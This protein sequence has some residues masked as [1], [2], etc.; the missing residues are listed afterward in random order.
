MIRHTEPDAHVVVVA[1]DLASLDSVRHFADTLPVDAV[2][3]LV[4]NAATMTVQRE[5]T[6]D[7]FEMMFGTNVLGHFALVTA[8]LDR[9][10]AAETPRVVTQS[11][12]GHR[13]GRLDFDDLQHERSFSG[14]S[15]YFDAKLAQHVLAVELDRRLAAVHSVVSQPGWVVTEL[16]RDIF[17]RGPLPTRAVFRLGNAVI[18]Q[19][20]EDG[21]RS[22]LTAALGADVPG[23]ATGQYVTPTKLNRLR[24]I[25]DIRPADPRVLDHNLGTRLWETASGLSAWQSHPAT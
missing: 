5:T 13:R 22:A 8:L 4:L 15:A 23:A 11:S 1:L 17:A 12:E 10:H 9:L 16:G 19:R 14:T 24:G 21:A 25:P 7:G 6:A 2:D 18:G 3:R 20:P